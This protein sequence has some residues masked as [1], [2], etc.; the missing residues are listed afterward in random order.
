M[1]HPF[2]SII[3]LFIVFNAA[4]ARMVTGEVTCQGKG[5]SK[6]IVTDGESFTMTSA[7]GKF[8]FDIDDNAE[9]VYIVT[10]SGY[11]ADW[12]NGSPEFYRKA[13]DNDSFNF[14]LTRTGDGKMNIIFLQ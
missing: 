11:V 14:E 10:P 12:S 9:F 5:I 1:K 2:L 6:V 13:R 8:S 4:N 7:G 3:C